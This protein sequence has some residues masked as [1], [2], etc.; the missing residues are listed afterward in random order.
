MDKRTAAFRKALNEIL[1]QR[2][3]IQRG[4]RDDIVRALK[5]ALDRIKVTL[6]SQPSD[7]QAWSLPQLEQQI[8][9]VLAEF[10]TS[11]SQTI[12]SAA[13]RSWEAGIASVD[14]PLAAGGA[15]IAAVL[16]LIDTRALSAMRTFM[17]GRIADI[18]ETAARKITSELGL[19]IIGAQTPS[20]AIAK[21]AAQLETG[22]RARATTIVRTELGRAFS[23]AAHERQSLAAEILPGMKKQWRRSGKIHSRLHHDAID[24]QIQDVDKPFV[25]GNGVKIMY[26]RDPA[27]PAAET[28]NCGCESLPYMDS[29]DVQTPGRRAFSEREI[30]LDKTKSDLA[31]GGFDRAA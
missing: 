6:T 28:I 24:G 16:P 5:L 1:K 19:V 2:T 13:S 23:T 31:A 22:G 14:A 27:A 17:V 18:S 3:S 11:A 10:R 25:L 12:G 7:Y 26:P 4:T 15:H 29:W 30:A 20:D 9:Q 8:R 21:I